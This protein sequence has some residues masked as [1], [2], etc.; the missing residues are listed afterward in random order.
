MKI[1][2]LLLI[3]LLIS[4]KNDKPTKIVNEDSKL[5]IKPEVEETLDNQQSFSE[6][7]L[8]ADYDKNQQRKREKLLAI[9]DKKEQLG[10]L[11]TTKTF[12]KETDDYI[13]DYRYPYLKEASHPSH[14]K[15]NTY[16][17]ENYLNI[18]A[19]ENE[20]LDDKELLCDTLNIKR[21][22][23]KRSIDYKLFS[24]K[25]NLISVVLYKENYYSGT[26]HSNY[27]FDCLNFDTNGGEFMTFENFFQ[28]NTEIEVLSIINKTI[29][30][31]IKDGELFYEC[32]EL[33]SGD[34]QVYKNNFVIN[35]TL[36]TFYFDDCIVCPSFTGTYAI[37]IPIQN[38]KTL[39]KKD[40][41]LL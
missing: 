18:V 36:L 26:V 24:A 37:D 16:I 14:K 3:L 29:T 6:D 12:L 11:V 17:K 23:D 20:I 7:K 19:T 4:C 22:M 38:F 27:G 9:K 5:P 40:N 39:L 41:F 10:D 32:W 8:T 15:F 1:Q 21:S 25:E 13:L 2:S 34:F 31:N 30:A 33:S 28:S 35:D